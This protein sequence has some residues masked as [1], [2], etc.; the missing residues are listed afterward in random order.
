MTRMVNRWRHEDDGLGMITV[1]L[2]MAVVSGLIV[3]AT[4]LAVS[5]TNNQRRDRQSLGALASSEAGVAQALQYIRGGNLAS[6]TCQEPAAGATPGAS[7][8]GTGPSWISATNPKEIRVDG[9]TGGC[10][11]SSDCFKVWIGTVRAFTPSCPARHASPP[12]QCYGLYRIHS[13][14]LSGN[15]PGARRVA[16]DVKAAPF[17]YPLGVFSETD[18]S[19]NGNVGIHSESVFTG[20]CIINRQDDSQSGSGFQFQWDSANNRPV[21]DLFYD[22]PAAAHAVAGVST[23]NNGTCTSTQGQAGPIH[24]SG[25]CNST[26]KWDQDNQGGPLPS[27]SP[28]RGNYVRSDGTV[29]PTTSQFTSQDLQDIGYRPRGLTDSQYDQLKAQAQAEGT[30]NIAHASISSTLTSLANAGVTSP[31]LYWDNGSVSLS[32]NDFPAA[33]SRAANSSAGCAQ[34]SVTIIVAGAGHNLSYQ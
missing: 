26:F 33:F 1:I 28:C 2:L 9:G 23:V 27:G 16:V 15:G 3:T 31:V 10:V 25:I 6:L 32:Q 5:N 14:G 22:Q 30:Y 19:G 17:S 24:A 13:T 18:F 29:Y 20:G 11:L 8:Q 34:S 7:C 4:A 12:G 21:I